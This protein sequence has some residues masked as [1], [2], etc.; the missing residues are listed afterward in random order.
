MHAAIYGAGKITGSRYHGISFT[1]SSRYFL[2][3]SSNAASF[4]LSAS[5]TATTSSFLNNGITI[6]DFDRLLQAMWPGNF[7]T[8]GTIKDTAC[9]QLV[10]HTPLLFLM[11]VQATGP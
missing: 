11:R 6:S 1:I 4:K 3:V 7:S 8:S 5:S 10:P 9:A 2:S